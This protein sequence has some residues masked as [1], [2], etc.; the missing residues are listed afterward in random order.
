M[1]ECSMCVLAFKLLHSLWDSWLNSFFLTLN[2]FLIIKKQKK[3]QPLSSTAPLSIS[4]VLTSVCLIA[5]YNST[6][7]NMRYFFYCVMLSERSVEFKILSLL[8]DSMSLYTL[9][10]IHY[11]QKLKRINFRVWGFIIFAI[12][13]YREAHVYVYVRRGPCFLK[14]LYDLLRRGLWRPTA[15]RNT[16]SEIS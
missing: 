15:L 14:F 11:T 10:F 5:K 3:A 6:N 4:F 13:W 1:Y 9:S 8:I 12:E 16:F 7:N 2:I